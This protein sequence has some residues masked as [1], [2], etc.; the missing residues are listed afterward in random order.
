MGDLW[1]EERCAEHL[2]KEGYDI[3]KM[4]KVL[5]GLNVMDVLDSPPRMKKDK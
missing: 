2:V 1:S 5:C 3:K 4:M